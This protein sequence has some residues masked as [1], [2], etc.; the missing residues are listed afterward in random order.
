MTA[1][2]LAHGPLGIHHA[3]VHVTDW[4]ASIHFYRDVLGFELL[5]D[6]VAT[7]DELVQRG[8][9]FLSPPVRFEEPVPVGG[10][11][12]YAV[13]PSGVVI[14]FIEDVDYS[15]GPVGGAG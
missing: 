10:A 12:V 13:D 14:E 9:Q 11:F 1:G 4:D 15:D 2:P 3:A 7:Y 8:V 5:A 6:V